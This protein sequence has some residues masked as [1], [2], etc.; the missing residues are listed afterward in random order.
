M[1]P[2]W[3]HVVDRDDYTFLLK[4]QAV[5]YAAPCRSMAGEKDLA[6]ALPS[7]EPGD[8]RLRIG[9]VHGTTFDLTGHETNFPIHR[10][11]A[12]LRGLDYLAI[13]DTHS[14]RDVCPGAVPTVYPGAP[15]STKFGEDDSGHVALVFFPPRG[16]RAM[17]RKERVGRW[18][19]R[20]VTCRDLASL[21]AL[22]EEKELRHSVVRLILDMTVTIQEMEEV[23]NI[24]TELKGTESTHARIEILQVDRKNLSVAAKVPQDAFPPDL[25][26]ALKTTVA[27]LQDQAAGPEGEIAARALFHLLKLVHARV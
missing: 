2:A 6:L 1:L 17:V 19:W 16:R 7:R 24:L 11:A 8:T 4:E 20:E 13:G 27:L 12:V 10:D 3:V 25:P 9:L 14:F 22:G 26:D 18:R 5:L 23:E 21:R 15:E